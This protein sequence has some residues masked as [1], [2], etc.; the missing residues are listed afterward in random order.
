MRNRGE[1]RSRHL[2]N[3]ACA[4]AAA[5]CLAAACSGKRD[6]AAGD[7]GASAKAERAENGDA[8]L[9]LDPT[10]S[11]EARAA[12][13]VSRMTLEEKAAQM[14]DKAPAIERL[15]VPVYNWWNEALHGVARAG[16]ATVFPQ[17]IGLAATWDEDLMLEVAQTISDEA[18]AKYHFY[19]SEDVRAMYGGLTFWSPNINI[20]RDPRWGRGQ[21]TYGEDPF[22]TGRM[23][24]NFI[25][26]LQGDDDRYWKTVA[27]VKHYA[28]H[29]GPEST[30]HSDDYNPTEADLWETYL[31]AF[32]VS[33]KET[34]VASVMCAYNAYRG[35][36]ACGSEELM[37]T[38]LRGRL[39]F[40]G[41]VVSDCG[42]IG[43]FYY[44]TAHA[45][46]ATM[47]EAAA[48]SVRMG[49]DLN[50]GDGEGSKMRALPEAVAKG[51]I[52]EATID[53]AVTR[54]FTARMK[55]GMFDD[56][57]SVPYTTIPTSE[58]AS[59]ENLA[60][61]ERASRASLVLLKNDG[62]LPLRPGV[63]AA[64]IGPN[65]DNPMTLIGNY[66]GIPT[67]P[68]TALA[69]VRAKAGDQN[70]FYAPGSA[71]AGDVY[72]NY[73]AVPASALFHETADGNYVPGLR[74]AYYADRDRKGE[75]AVTRIDPNIDFYWPRSPATNGLD[76]EFGAEWSGVIAPE[77]D[78]AYRFKASMW[79]EATVNGEPVEGRTFNLKA[80]ERYP[81]T[82]TLTLDSSWHRDALEKFAH[83]EWVDVSRDLRAEALAAAAQADVVLFFG[84][85]DANLEGEEMNVKID[86]FSGGDRTNLLLP[87]VQED[88]LKDLHALGKPIVLVNFSGS[89]MALNWADENVGAIVQAFYPGE[90]AGAAIA[91][92]LWGEFSPSGRLPVT[93]YRSL[94]GL[95]AFDDY[96]MRNRTYK[97]YEGG[98]LY[99]FGHGL[100]YTSFGYAG[101]GAP[102]NHDGL[103]PLNV[104]VTVSNTGEMAGREVVQAYLSLD[105]RPNASTPRRELVG[106]EV[107]DL[108]PGESRSVEFSIPANRLGYY[109]EDG[110]YTPPHGM[111]A[112]ISIGG[113]QPGADGLDAPSVVRK[114]AF[115]AP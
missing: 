15:G 93:F 67:A 103:S 64:V 25:N 52:D 61:A 69:G 81:V 33:I 111:T 58:V 36:P 57:G 108:A 79:M 84:G 5:L 41:Y 21:E 85:I 27:T 68:V 7:E 80:G 35:A 10:Q 94:E 32:A 82:V 42:A 106:F 107:V 43:D 49:T 98:P 63:K 62:V 34:D 96:S 11:F 55:L 95:P 53:R 37:Q 90:R 77:K 16:E 101:L 65:A 104:S 78:G 26:G 12:D 54:L 18:R 56:P 113:G 83:F 110:T 105:S 9:Y 51:L 28:V 50:C 72:V 102:D 14:Y 20:F 92:L 22:L 24:V 99:P 19:I 66:H 6:A 48:L 97:Y 45:H 74:A 46:V 88:L 23:A 40:D 60:L 31:D 87:K 29:S 1:L 86:G 17:A 2:R 89:A 38:L 4:A 73:E 100:S 112:T 3:T 44:P 8:P 109:A 71:M 39:G 70:V 114:V 30:R 75:P 76:D 47:A 59:E 91:D 115:A 13:L